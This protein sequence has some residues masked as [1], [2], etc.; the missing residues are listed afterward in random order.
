[1]TFIIFFCLV[2]KQAPL[3]DEKSGHIISTSPIINS[4]YL[5]PLTVEE[6]CTVTYVL[7]QILSAQTVL[8][9]ILL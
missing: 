9:L 1:M 6:L 2:Y 5:S 4:P 7:S 8:H 3:Y